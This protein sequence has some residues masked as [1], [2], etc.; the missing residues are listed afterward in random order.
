MPNIGENFPQSR[1]ARKE[2]LIEILKNSPIGSIKIPGKGRKS[3]YRI[4]LNYLSYNPHNTRFLAQAKTLEKRLG[5][6]LSDEIPADIEKIE[7][8]LWNQKI[9]ENEYTINSL[10]EDGQLQP[11]VVT[12]DGIILSGNRRFRLLNEISRNNDKYNKPGVSLEGLDYFEAAILENEL[13]EKEIV[14]FESFYQYGTEDKVE[15]DPIQKYIAAADQRNLGYTEQQIAD[16]F[17]SI[18]RGKAKEVKLW[19]EVF[20]LMEEYLDYIGEEGIYTALESSEE[21]FLRLRSDLR[22]FTSGRAGGKIWPYND[23][24]LQN[25][26]FRYFDY[27]R[28]NVPTHDVRIFKKIFLDEQRWKKFNGEVNEVVEKNDVD[29]FENYRKNYENEQEDEVSKIRNHDFKDKAEKALKQIYGSEHQR[30][31]AEETHETPIRIIEQIQQKLEKIE[32]A[33][34]GN[35]NEDGFKTGEFLNAVIDIQKRIGRIKQD[36]D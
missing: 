16:H 19:L 2:K 13:N 1:V 18:T 32:S 5:K 9:N 33:I 35:Q 4:P 21:A 12:L 30:I 24:D 34:S 7:E 10:I 26:K 3:V 27:I 17:M 11:G 23:F 36:I 8:Y 20:D 22:S 6:K 31:I 28:I 15:Y 14:K 29:T 25:L